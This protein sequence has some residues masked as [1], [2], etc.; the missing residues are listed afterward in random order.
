MTA[1]IAR[2]ELKLWFLAVRPLTLPLSVSPVLVGAV[3]SLHRTGGLDWLLLAVT[4]L[5]A[6]AIQAGTN[7]LNDVEDCERGND[8]AARRGPPRITA[9]GWALA[10]E[11]RN[12]AVLVFLFAGLCGLYLAAR[13][14]WP[15]MA[16]G[17]VSI[18]A[19]I[20]YSAGPRPISHSPFG[21][22]FVFVFFGI[23]AVGGT[24]FLQTG[25]VSLVA[26]LSGAIMGSFAAAVL[27][28]NNTRDISEDEAAGRQ[29][30][31]IVLC[32]NKESGKCR[33]Q[34]RHAV[35]YAL[36]L[37]VPYVLS[38]LQIWW[39]EAFA[40]SRMIW[41]ALVC[42]P[43]TVLVVFRFFEAETGDQ[44]NRILVMTIALQ[45]MFATLFSLGLLI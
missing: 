29:T 23:I 25:G 35:L 20:A 43:W 24:F 11:V 44:Y 38:G 34:R 21:E 8:T 19:G 2:T 18:I 10:A 32:G 45:L 36:F 6:I 17:L 14:G 15:I 40:A 30:L 5:A 31:A 7:L 39:L 9:R 27:H 41:P 1:A 22:L 16:I 13:G 28:V 42:I 12:A 37:L 26:L 3:L 4:L 33:K